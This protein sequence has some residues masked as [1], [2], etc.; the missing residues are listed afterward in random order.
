MI[1]PE[2]YWRRRVVAVV[3]SIAAVVV[4]A[5]IIGRLVGT[6]DQSPVEGA[7]ARASQPPSSP[8]GGAHPGSTSA[9]ASSTAPPVAATTTTTTA[10]P[11]PPGPCPDAVIKVLAETGAPGYRVGQRPLL[12]LVVVNAG[13]LACVRE[14]GRS[15]RELVI[16]SADGATR[17]WSSN[18]CYPP[19]GAESRLLQPGERLEFTV[20]WAGRTSA[21][22]CPSR[23]RSLPAGTYL[24]TAKLGAL[25]SPP[26]PLELTG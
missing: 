18:D 12:R 17:L 14:V 11:A 5:W 10:P 7:A 16:T 25:A 15:L 21:P 1:D 3:M 13:Q 20:N 2:V 19:P 6:A 23:R 9:S 24:V 4:L 26:A 22:G 8:P